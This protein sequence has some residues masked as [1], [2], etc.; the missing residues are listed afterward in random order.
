MYKSLTLLAVAL[1]IAVP[2]QYAGAAK[3]KTKEAKSIVL[4]EEY[5]TPD[6][7]VVA[8]CGTMYLIVLNLEVD[9]PA[10]ILKVSKENKVTKLVDLPA[11]PETKGVYPLGIAIGSDGNLYVADN[12]TFGSHNDH[13]SRLLR[14][15]MKDGKPGKVETVAEGFIAANAVEPFGDAIY[16]TETTLENDSTPHTSAIYRLPLDKLNPESPLKLKPN[17]A[18]PHMI[19]KLTTK[20]DTWIK[21][22]GANG[23][24]ITPEGMLY[25]CNF[26]EA[27]I[28]GAKLDKDGKLAGELKKINK[29][30]RIKSTDGMHWIPEKKLLVV[31]D[32]HGNAIHLVDPA[33]GKV[34]TIAK[35]KN[36]TG[37]KGLLD[38]PSEPCYRDGVIYASNIDLPLDENVTDRPHTLSIIQVDWD[39]LF[40]PKVKKERK[41]KKEAAK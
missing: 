37:E 23:M 27:S 17:G 35:N 4:A 32:F 24:T 33:T 19:A 2:A 21:D 29:G 9:A 38:K 28:L 31:A 25:V 13:K 26:G 22:V 39:K 34:A 18:D 7:M 14:V 20:G 41:P 36:S 1:L 12:Q 8:P 6:G 10:A 3:G 11:H 16:V 5:S 30:K 15:E 40:Q